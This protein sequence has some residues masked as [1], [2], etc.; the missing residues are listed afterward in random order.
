RS[1][2]RLFILVGIPSL[3]LHLLVVI[4]LGNFINSG[5]VILWGMVFPVLVSLIFFDF[6]QAIPWIM[7]Y[8]LNVVLSVALQPWLRQATNMPQAVVLTIFGLNLLGVSGF[9]IGILA[10]FVG[11]RNLA[12]RL[13][14]EEQAKSENLLL[15]I[16]PHDIAT[17]LK[18]E[19]RT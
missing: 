15:N 4:L 18:G 11:Q 10:Y 12:Y 14:H 1:Y 7:A 5:A 19:T 2:K 9:T 3:P 13:L 6:R 8:G 17:I 16:L